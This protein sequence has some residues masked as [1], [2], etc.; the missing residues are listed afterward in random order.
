M[1]GVRWWSLPDLDTTTDV[2]EP[3]GLAGLV[4]RIVSGESLALPVVLHWGAAAALEH[5][6]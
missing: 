1:L 4:R 3:R 6:A 2:I 5:G